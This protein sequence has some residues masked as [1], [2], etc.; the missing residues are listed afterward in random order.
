MFQ[1]KKN[2]E[3]PVQERTGKNEPVY[4]AIVETFKAMS[5]GDCFDVP[6]DAASYNVLKAKIKHLLTP[7][8]KEGEYYKYIA[9][10]GV[11]QNGENAGKEGNT[12]TRIWKI[13]SKDVETNAQG[14][15]QES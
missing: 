10:K 11:I 4:A 6:N 14:E 9:L 13:E 12:G 15:I 2:V 8:L 5:V 1:I 3:I 7:V